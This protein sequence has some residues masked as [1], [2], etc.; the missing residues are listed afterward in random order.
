MGDNAS[1]LT[2]KTLVGA[3]T[4]SG[5]YEPNKLAAK[6]AAASKGR[7]G[8][9]KVTT[10]IQIHDGKGLKK[11]RV[12]VYVSPY[13]PGTL[14]RAVSSDL[15][16]RWEIGL[17]M[18]AAQEFWGFAD[19]IVPALAG[20]GD[21]GELRIEQP[22][23]GGAVLAL[24]GAVYPVVSGACTEGIDTTPPV[25]VQAIRLTAEHRAALLACVPFASSDPQRENLTGV[26]VDPTR[27]AAFSSDGRQVIGKPFAADGGR[28]FQVPP[29]LVALLKDDDFDVVWLMAWGDPATGGRVTAMSGANFHVCVRAPGEMVNF[30]GVVSREG[31]VE[32]KLRAAPV[33][34]E[35]QRWKKPRP[36][37]VVLEILPDG[38]VRLHLS[39]D[40]DCAGRIE[41]EDALVGDAPATSQLAGFDPKLLLAHLEAAPT[42]DVSL[43]IYNPSEDAGA[44]DYRY[45]L[46]VSGKAGG[47]WM[48][49]MGQKHPAVPAIWTEKRT[50][51]AIAPAEDAAE[52]AGPN[53]CDYDDEAEFGDEAEKPAPVDER[54]QSFV[55]EP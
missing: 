27:N 35:L 54:Q 6:L 38:R 46:A 8:D 41:L 31:K 22:E 43:L 39:I 18:A 10:Q 19:L 7:K 17:P 34:A 12:P 40:Y 14:C 1:A 48:V 32:V 36:S 23:E 42:G 29:R 52:G 55:G 28:P 47:E 5:I 3:L 11:P 13:G 33:L 4:T 50:A 2:G 49:T 9:P 20:L 15:V 16:F 24:P 37:E 21:D 45:A 44:N 53:D 30:Y 25:D 51:Q 26:W